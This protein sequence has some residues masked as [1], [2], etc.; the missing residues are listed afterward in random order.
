MININ[1]SLAITFSSSSAFI[2]NIYDIIHYTI[3]NRYGNN[4]MVVCYS[5]HIHFYFT[6]RLVVKVVSIGYFLSI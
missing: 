6:A 2:Q 1:L 4:S 5:E 3:Y